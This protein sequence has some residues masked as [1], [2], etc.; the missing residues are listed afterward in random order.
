MTYRT[1]DS[2]VREIIDVEEDKDLDRFIATASNLVDWLDAQDTDGDL[3]ST[4]LQL[5]EMW[6]AAHFYAH[7][8]QLYTQRQT[9]KSMAIFQGQTGMNLASTQYGQT[10]MD[11]DVTNRLRARSVGKK[12]VNF[13]WLGTDYEDL[14]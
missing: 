2:E 4:T 14:D 12:K 6:L 13:T 5:I 9:G 10:A 7:Y 3:S 11:L 8:D 1:T